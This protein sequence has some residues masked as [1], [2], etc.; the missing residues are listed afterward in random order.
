MDVL[1]L[2]GWSGKNGE[3]KVVVEM[4]GTFEVNR[5]RFERN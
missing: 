1:Y 3:C 4:I 2:Y 5:Q